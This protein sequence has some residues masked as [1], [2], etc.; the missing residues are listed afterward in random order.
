MICDVENSRHF[1]STVLNE[2]DSS[3]GL[4][5]L[6]LQ[7]LRRGNHGH[8]PRTRIPLRSRACDSSSQSS[9]PL[10]YYVRTS[11]ATCLPKSRR[12]IATDFSAKSSHVSD[13][14]RALFYIETSRC[15][16]RRTLSFNISTTFP[17]STGIRIHCMSLQSLWS[18]RDF[19]VVLTK[20]LVLIIIVSVYII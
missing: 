5:M 8:R 19:C 3:R 20:V 18:F 13:A 2:G 15:I 6:Q 1:R 14:I 4:L 12:I 7:S 10:C 17:R 9:V 16:H 11:T